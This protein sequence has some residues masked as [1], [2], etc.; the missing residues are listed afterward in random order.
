M[1]ALALIDMG[2]AIPV[3]AKALED[4]YYDVRLAAATALGEIADPSAIPVLSRSLKEDQNNDIRIEIVRAMRLINHA[5]TLTPL[6]NALLIDQM[7]SVR[8]E[9][10]LV[11]SMSNLISW[12]KKADLIIQILR[13]SE[14]QRADVDAVNVVSAMMPPNEFPLSE[15]YALTDYLIG[16]AKDKLQSILLSGKLI[17]ESEAKASFLLVNASTSTRKYIR[18]RKMNLKNC[19]LR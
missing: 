10:S 18:F 17:I 7:P 8:Q 6:V 16:M 3:I 4:D 15:K 9:I 13:E 12:Q 2:D 14:L 1:R 19:A 5:D 11:L